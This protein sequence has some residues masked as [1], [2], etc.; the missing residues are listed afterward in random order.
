[1]KSIFSIAAVLFLMVSC[2]RNNGTVADDDLLPVVV[3]NAPANGQVFAGGSTVNISAS[4]TDNNRL[5]EVHV[6]ISDRATGQQLIDIHRYPNASA[7]TL[8]ETFQVQ[9]GINYTVRVIAI[10]RAGN[11]GS[12]TVLIMVN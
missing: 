11:S 5:A 2:S 9:S 4:I 8:N 12:Q 3:L 6:H 10:D 7:Y 1:M